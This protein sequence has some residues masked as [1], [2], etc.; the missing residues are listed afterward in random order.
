M[1]AGTEF[2][3]E[4]CSRLGFARGMAGSLRDP[5]DQ[6]QGLAGRGHAFA[7]GTL[8][9]RSLR[10]RGA[11][12]ILLWVQKGGERWEWFNNLKEI[13]KQRCMC[14]CVF[15]YLY[16]WLSASMVFLLGQVLSALGLSTGYV[17][18]NSHWKHWKLLEQLLEATNSVDTDPENNTRQ[19]NKQ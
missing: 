11:G 3:M 19:T 2:A 4:S 9:W 1:Q 16:L 6:G 10:F 13:K 18:G 5:V 17:V 15:C 7:G 14:V 12:P 8:G